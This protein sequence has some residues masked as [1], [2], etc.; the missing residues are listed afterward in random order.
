MSHERS[1]RSPGE[2]GRESCHPHR[3]LTRFNAVEI[4]SSFYKPHRRQTYE[5][6][7]ASAPPDFAFS[8]KIPKAI[9]HELRLAAAAMPLFDAFLEQAQGLGTKLRCLLVQLP[10]SLA[11][12]SRLAGRFGANCGNAT[13]DR[14]RSSRATRVGSLLKRM[15][16]SRTSGSHAYSPIPCATMQGPHRVGG[17]RSFICGFTAHAE[18]TGPGTRRPA[19]IARAATA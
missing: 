8:V 18:C 19:G 6:W 17:K 10:P 13:L 11:F 7:A 2:R 12:D 15:F 14:S 3:M 1:C 9:T 16:C 4:N 5:R